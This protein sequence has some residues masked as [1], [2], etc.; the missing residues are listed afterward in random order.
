M[1]KILI[2]WTTSWIWNYLWNLLKQKHQIIWLSKSENNIEWIDFLK[3]NLENIEEINAIK[4]ENIDY[5]I[6]NAWVWFF[7]KFENI[8]LENHIKIINTNLIW[9][10]S[11]VHKLL[12]KINVWIIF[13]WSLSSKKSQKLWASYSA[14][15]FWLRWFAMSLKN[16]NNWKKIF[17]I[18]PKIVK[19]NLHKNS[20]IEIFWKF[21]E[22][23]LEEIWACIESILEKKENRFEIDL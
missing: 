13:M 16:E 7:D 1:S 23:S 10:I 4:I 3:I 11:L 9:N 6:L 14:S 2:T 18:N 22:T 8:S 5:L 21:S 15:K 20:K 19:S 17:F 12:D